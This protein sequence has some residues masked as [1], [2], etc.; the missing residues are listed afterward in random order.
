MEDEGSEPAAAANLEKVDHVVVVMLE[1]RSFDHMLGYLSLNGRRPDVDGLRL[2]FI[3]EHEGRSYPVHHRHTTAIPM[4]PDHSASGID[5]Q[6]AGGAMTGF[7]T[8][9]AAT[10]ARQGREDGDPACVMGYYDGADVPVYD[11]LAEEF[12]V[13]DRWFSSVAGSTMPNRLYALCGGAGGSRD[14]RPVYVPPLYHQAS[15][16]RHLDPHGVSWRWY[17]FDPGMLRMAD[18]DYR[19]GHL[20]TILV[21]FCPQALRD[22]S[23]APRPR[24][25]MAMGPHHPGRRVVQANHLGELLSRTAPRPAPRRD[26]LLGHAAARSARTEPSKPA[27]AA[28]AGAAAPAND[29]ERS[30]LSA[31]HELRRQGH[32]PNTP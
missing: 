8:S 16:V 32:P 5:Q 18:V 31:T 7:V 23:A 10:P 1:N 2:G 27:S 15:F 19:L 24:P 26:A 13:C 9:A 21:R 11:H 4:D 29:L 3:N 17:S 30:I 12:A 22:Q 25:T 14:N 28:V 20:N 6:V